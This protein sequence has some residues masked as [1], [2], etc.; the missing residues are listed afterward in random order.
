MKPEAVKYL[1]MAADM[2][3][4]VAF[5]QNTMGFDQGHV[6]PCWS[7]L[8]FGDAILALHGGGEGS[9]NPTGLSLQYADVRQAHAAAVAAGAVSIHEPEQRE[10]EPIILATIADPEGNVIML[11]QYVG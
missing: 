10:G 6:S 8:R 1:L 5:Y 3:R 4:A 2:D 11:T 7:E 9:R